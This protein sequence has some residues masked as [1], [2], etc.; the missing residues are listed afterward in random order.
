[1]TAHIST[2]PITVATNSSPTSM[3]D[4]LHQVADNGGR[5]AALLQFVKRVA[6]EDAEALRAAL[7]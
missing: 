2:P 3:V 4:A 5:Q 1:M 6:A 7:A